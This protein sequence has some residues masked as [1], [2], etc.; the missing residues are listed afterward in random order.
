M[1]Q[2]ATTNTPAQI[3]L[4]FKNNT[5]IYSMPLYQRKYCWEKEELE[6]FNDDIIEIYNQRK[7][8]KQI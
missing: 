5:A 2:V 8:N 1:L 7:I 3:G 6:R 4:I